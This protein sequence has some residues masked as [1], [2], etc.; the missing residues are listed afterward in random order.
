MEDAA[1]A[2]VE[3]A[4]LGELTPVVFTEGWDLDHDLTDF[5]RMIRRTERSPKTAKTYAIEAEV[6][7]RYLRQRHGKSLAEATEQDFWAYRTFRREGPLNIR[8]NP[9]SWNKIAAVL[10]RLIHHRKLA[11]PEIV[12]SKFR[13]AQTEDKV[14]MIPIETYKLFRDQ[15]MAGGRDRLRNQ[16]F[17]ELLVTTGLRCAEGAALLRHE[18]PGPDTFGQH[19]TLEV[20]VPAAITKGSKAR[21]I[22]YSARVARDYVDAYV[23]EERSHHLHLAVEQFFPRRTYRPSALQRLEGWIFFAP[24]NPSKIRIVAGEGVQG[25]VPSAKLTIEERR[26]LVEVKPS[27]TGR[28][29][30]VVDFGS[31][32]LGE[33]GHPLTPAGWNAVFTQASKRLRAGSCPDAHVTPHVLRHTYA[34]Y[35]LNAMLRALLGIR[36]R[37][38]HL[39]RHSEI[40]ERIIGDPLYTLQRLLGHRAF[41]TTLKYLR[42]VEDN[43]TLIDG[44]VAEW[45]RLIGPEAVEIPNAQLLPFPATD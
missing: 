16:A 4:A 45:D 31:L 9:A 37:R 22:H 5:T 34:V 33:G 14:R 7:V 10:L 43:Q 27:P 21:T 20:H 12:W 6:F 40:Y 38:R 8:L 32:W 17:A 28:S 36:S 18:L 11:C 39:D 1:L 15:G 42:Y 13:G 2:A 41:R 19:R 35:T 24:E 30:E 26:K 29:L 23:S 25:V 44:A 3:H